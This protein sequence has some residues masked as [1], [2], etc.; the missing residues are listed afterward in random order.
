MSIS[1]LE[2]R[3]VKMPPPETFLGDLEAAQIVEK[4]NSFHT[5]LSRESHLDVAPFAET[6]FLNL[7]ALYP[8]SMCGK[9]MTDT[10]K[11]VAALFFFGSQPQNA[12]DTA[13]IDDEPKLRELFPRNKPSP[14]HQGYNVQDI[15]LILDRSPLAI[16]EALK[17]KEEEAKVIL[18]EAELRSTTQKETINNRALDTLTEALTEEEKDT[19]AQT[20]SNASQKPKKRA[21]LSC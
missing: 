15:A 18:E 13:K 1:D 3:G 4:I 10:L 16:V 12:T 17:Q 19:L 20:E 2:L 21:E 5:R 6:Y 8:V 11:L 9:N 14:T 7:I